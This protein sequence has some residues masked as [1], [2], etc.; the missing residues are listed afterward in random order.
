[1]GW[2]K[3]STVPRDDL[4][5]QNLKF[6]FLFNAASELNKCTRSKEVEEEEESVYPLWGDDSNPTEKNDLLSYIPAPKPKF[7]GHG[8]SFNPS[9]EY[10]PTQ[11]EINSYQLMYE[12]DHPKFIPKRGHEDA[13]TSVSVEASGQ[14]IASG[15]DDIL[16]SLLHSVTGQDIL[17]LNTGCGNEE[18][19]KRTKELLS[20]EMP[21]MTL[22]KQH[23]V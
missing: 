15:V 12:E 4:F 7:P 16:N 10:I 17:L 8:E 3:A 19:Q 6:Y 23:P 14:W 22:A 20:V 5:L 21:V 2:L 9:L 11:E 18:V 1:M 13:V